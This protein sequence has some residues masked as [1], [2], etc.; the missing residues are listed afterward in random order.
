[1]WFFC[2]MS[3]EVTTRAQCGHPISKSDNHYF[4]WTSRQQPTKI[5]PKQSPS[6]TVGDMPSRVED[7]EIGQAVSATVRTML[8]PKRLYAGTWTVRL[9]HSVPLHS[10]HGGITT[11]IQPCY[12][13]TSRLLFML[14]GPYTLNI[15]ILTQRVV[16]LTLVLFVI[17]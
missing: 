7:C 13:A 3:A 15:L 8:V 6:Q 11:L 10:S 5:L 16:C 12:M 1:M 2:K 4:W 9:V 14:L 17:K